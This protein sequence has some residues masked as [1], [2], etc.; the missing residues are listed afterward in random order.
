[1]ECLED[2]LDGGFVAFGVDES[3]EDDSTGLKVL[4]DLEQ[5]NLDVFAHVV[6]GEVA[7]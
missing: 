6:F 2:L 3:A 4:A 5:I 1:M 7:G